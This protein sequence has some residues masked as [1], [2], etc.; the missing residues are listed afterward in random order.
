MVNRKNFFV[1]TFRKYKD[2][3]WPIEN[4]EI[5]K[6]LSITALLFSILFIQNIIRAL[7]DSMVNTMISAEAI[8]FLKFWGVLPTAFLFAIVYVKLTNVMKST[9]IFYLILSIFV[10]FFTF[11]AFIILPN[12]EFFHMDQMRAENFVLAYPNMKWFILI[13]AKWSFSLFYIIAELWPSVVFALLFWQFVNTITSVDESKRFYILFGLLGQTGLYFSG[14]FLQLSPKIGKYL[15]EHYNLSASYSTISLQC[16]LTLVIF[17][18]L[19]TIYIFKHINKRFVDTKNV[20]LDFSVKKDKLSV[21]DSFKM[22]FSSSYIMLIAMLLICYGV[23]INLVEGPWK[24]QARIVYPDAA[25]YAAFVGSYLK[26][27]GILTV[28]FVLL[29][30]N[31]VRKVGWLAA[32]VI[33]PIMVFVTGMSFFL[34]SNSSLAAENMNIIFAMQDPIMLAVTVGAIQNVLSK[35]SKYTLFDA[36]KEMAYVPLSDEMKTKGKAAADVVGTKLGKGLSALLQSLIFIIFPSATYQSISSYIMIIF[37]VICIIWLFATFKLNKQ[38][39]NLV[40][41]SAQ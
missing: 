35:S 29:G 11:F 3:L 21:K 40:D 6:F 19:M 25:E 14:S 13:A 5:P 30:S 28:S 8:P 32:A 41:T 24:A 31:I 26:Y 17:F 10:V 12:I 37:A 22:I 7:K 15:V 2:Y 34:I 23:S 38:Y 1:N 4:H 39:Q 36:T 33:T 9:N 18:C 27:T 20:R 16:S